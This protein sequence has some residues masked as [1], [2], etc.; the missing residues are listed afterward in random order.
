MNNWKSSFDHLDAFCFN[1]ENKRHE[2]FDH[3]YFEKEPHYDS[4]FKPFRQNY[5]S[6]VVSND[7][8]TAP[9]R[10]RFKN[11]QGRRIS[12]W[13]VYIVYSS[14]QPHPQIQDCQ[15]VP[16]PLWR[17]AG[18][19]VVRRVAGV[20]AH[21]NRT[22][23]ASW[24][25]QGDG[26]SNVL[27]S[28]CKWEIGLKVLSW[29]L[30]NRKHMDLWAEL[31]TH[32]TNLKPRPFSIDILWFACSH[33]SAWEV[34]RHKHSDD[35][36]RKQTMVIYTICKIFTNFQGPKFGSFVRSPKCNK[37]AQSVIT[38]SSSHHDITQLRVG[39]WIIMIT[40]GH[41]AIRPNHLRI[42]LEMLREK[43][44]HLGWSQ[45][46]EERETVLGF[47]NNHPWT[48][49]YSQVSS[50]FEWHDSRKPMDIPVRLWGL[51]PLPRSKNTN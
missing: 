45:R 21:A 14:S 36:R 32:G 40:K 35:E 46:D 5:N 7:Q 50:I 6:S 4:I 38:R 43:A 13:D 11:I 9:Y 51:K 3:M 30:P 27:V 1:T 17:P 8:L 47:A 26:K 44:H 34:W 48:K 29:S 19:A 37:S 41:T 31:N 10:R 24:N 18:G 23:G 2:G 15:R 42:I 20:I 16:G 33:A 28:D 12:S 39:G 22:S 49:L 25:F